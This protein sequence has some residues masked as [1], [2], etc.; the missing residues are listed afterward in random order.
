M[1]RVIMIES[2]IKLCTSNHRNMYIHSHMFEL[3]IITQ[4]YLF[5]FILRKT[6]QI[7]FS[8]YIRTIYSPKALFGITQLRTIHAYLNPRK[9]NFTR[10]PRNKVRE[11]TGIRAVFPYTKAETRSCICGLVSNF[12]LR[13]IDFQAF[14]RRPFRR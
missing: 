13:R 12:K 11:S 10:A 5:S 14:Y 4:N 3:V 8:S 7:I 1:I 9:F 2:P 6:V